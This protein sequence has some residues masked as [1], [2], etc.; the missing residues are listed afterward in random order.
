[1]L[2]C[3]FAK[4]STVFNPFIYYFFSNSFKQEVKQLLHSCSV[5]QSSQLSKGTENGIYLVCAENK[6]ESKEKLSFQNREATTRF[7][8]VENE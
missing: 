2:P 3:L 7:S 8:S 1:M 5:Y 4:T 6:D